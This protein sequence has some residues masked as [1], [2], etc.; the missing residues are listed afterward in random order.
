MFERYTE[1]ARR[2]IFF[3]RYETS[4]FGSTAIETEHLLLGLIR[5]DRNIMDRFLG[6]SRQTDVRKEIEAR[7]TIREKIPT[8]IDLPLSLECKHIL[9]YAA[10]EAERLNHRHIGTEHLLLGILREEK[11]VA[12]EILHAQGFRLVAIREELAHAAVRPVEGLAR[13]AVSGIPNYV[14]PEGNVV[15]D[16]DTAKRVAEA[17]WMTRHADIVESQKPFVAELK[18]GVI[19]IVTGAPAMLGTERR[20]HAVIHKVD[21]R[22]LSVGKGPAIE[23]PLTTKWAKEEIATTEGKQALYTDADTGLYNQGFLIDVLR[24]EVALPERDRQALTL[25]ILDVDNMDLVNDTFGQVAGNEVLKF[26]AAVLRSSI[27]RDDFAFR[28]GGD[29]FAILLPDQDLKTGLNIAEHIRSRCETEV[30]QAI[31]RPVN[32]T[33]S[34]GVCQYE[35]GTGINTFI[36]CAIQAVFKAKMG[37]KNT[38]EFHPRKGRTQGRVSD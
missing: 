36:D 1:R 18:R 31:T 16:A 12:A 9:A 2:V 20:L 8:S 4:Q 15:P 23:L 29:K 32:V 37:G 27:T 30:G 33:V 10:E 38:V 35:A 28:Y 24:G 34:I 3:A 21:G 13:Q 5:E 26:V 17:I 19:W 14:S 7:T 11:C 25:L 6:G 22:I